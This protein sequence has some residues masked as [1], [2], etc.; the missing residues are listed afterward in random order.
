MPADFFSATSYQLPAASSNARN[1]VD[2]FAAAK[3]FWM[4]AQISGLI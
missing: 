2:Y 3:A 4:N 1:T